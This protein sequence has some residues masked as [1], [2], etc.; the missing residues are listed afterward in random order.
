VSY[1]PGDNPH[2]TRT[3]KVKAHKRR[4]K[5]KPK[6]APK[7]NFPSAVP[8]APGAITV[9]P[10]KPTG[11]KT[12]KALNRTARKQPKPVAPSPAVKE[13][14]AAKAQEAPKAARAQRKLE[15][16]QPVVKVTR[17][18]GTPT[19]ALVARLHHETIGQTR[20]DRRAGRHADLAAALEGVR[21][22]TR[23]EGAPPE[24]KKQK[25]V[26]GPLGTVLGAAELADKVLSGKAT[27][28]AVSTLA[29]GAASAVS[30]D[31]LEKVG[32]KAPKNGPG[33]IAGRVARGAGRDIVDLPANA[34]PS[35][36]VPTKQAVSGHPEEAAKTI[37][38]GAKEAVTHPLDHPIAA[39]LAV[40]GAEGALGHGIGKALRTA[41]SETAKR[42]GSLDR[43]ERKVANANIKAREQQRY[44]KDI[45]VKGAQVLA[46]RRRA[47]KGNVHMTADELKR[48]ADERISANED[49]R[50]TNRGEVVHEART[51]LDQRG[52][53]AKLK[54]HRPDAAT[55]LAAQH[56]AHTPAELKTYLDRLERQ[57]K[58]LKGDKLRRNKQAQKD[59][60]RALRRANPR[61]EE[62]AAKYREL[63]VR[64]QKELGDL[65][66]ISP[67]EMEQARLLAP[68]AA[69]FGVRAD[70]HGMYIEQP[71]KGRIDVTPEDVR[72]M[73]SKHG[74][75]D[76]P[77]FVTHAPGQRGARNFYVRQD[78]APEYRGPHR[79]GEGIAQGTADLN[80]EVLVEQV[81]R[82]QG[83]IDA[84]KGF[85]STIDEF[86][87]RDAGDQVQT[88]KNWQDA[89][90]AAR[91]MLVDHETGDF[92]QHAVEMTPV[93]LNPLGG[94][95]AQLD[96][97]LEAL[98]E[99]G[100]HQHITEA[101]DNA[102]SGADKGSPGD[103]ALIP[104]AVADR[105]REHLSVGQSGL[106]KIGQLYGGQF[107]KVVLSLSPKWL[108][109]NVVEAA[110]RT[111]VAHAGPRSALTGYK[112]QKEYAARYGDQAAAELR[113][114]TTGGGHNSLAYRTDVRRGAQDFADSGRK[115]AKLAEVMGKIRRTPGPK[116]IADVWDGY[117]HLVMK[118]L[119]GR[120]E[121]AFQTAQFGK[122]LRDSP[123][124]SDHTIKLSKAAMDDAVEGLHNTN[125]QVALGREVDRMYGR[126]SKFSPNKRRMI[127]GYTPFIAWYLNAVQF[128]FDV[129]P[130][131]H[132]VLT[133]VLAGANVA[134]D[135]WRKQHGL[136]TSLVDN[137]TQAP[138]FLQG[139]IPGKEG[140]N[141][142]VS[143]FTPFG[144]FGQ[145]GGVAGGFANSILPQFNGMIHNA[146]G[147]DWK[148]DK[149]K[150]NG[151][152]KGYNALAAAITLIE[153][154]VP[155]VSQ[156]A[157]LTGAHLPNEAEGTKHEATLPAR[158]RKAYDPF[159]FTKSKVGG[160]GG[161]D[162]LPD[163]TKLPK[164]PDVSTLKLPPLPKI[165]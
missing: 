121:H 98:H 142:R 12:A 22:R 49:V 35:L 110:L 90:D 144:V 82:T 29:K 157:T 37:Y 113:S 125:A 104:K 74:V 68:A 7:P 159:M 155:L 58:T 146:I 64:L 148:G 137:F 57:S 45:F 95:R 128:L 25:H 97:T 20:P 48:R 117:T 43:G 138:D 81:A 101:I 85:R 71:G 132:P 131:D 161:S 18:A 119:N 80:P 54:G 99:H 51:A 60:R 100:A 129:L 9:G 126:Y 34:I 164:V 79:T 152:T 160:G 84:A 78:K 92:H 127:A 102:L 135:E 114:R 89:A 77:A 86:A 47:R 13:Q 103:W 122:A 156:G 75:T 162:T 133:A 87:H 4:I 91:E 66:V 38:E 1:G 153:N 139:S 108:T 5:A 105:M 55:S 30:G 3:V 124:M 41:P 130:R 165:P 136:V 8:Q 16:E 42:V 27:Q 111:M 69:R 61:T 11:N 46:D 67:A 94:R 63:N 23:T 53:I 123:L 107:R 163:G 2:G 145:E 40:R 151:S 26:G 106:G 147:E 158:A 96:K 65:E 52:P 59:V 70:E 28:S 31:Y 149:L 118:S 76:E 44:N 10:T 109:G 50:R 19:A 33:A 56:I 73:L 39:L 112:A 32:L 143:R 72:T 62:Q 17:G 15:Q 88:F 36:Y 24:I 154:S 141:E 93:R 21:A 150:K 115:L 140:S 134:T 120:I 116:Q 83:L 14:H 6:N